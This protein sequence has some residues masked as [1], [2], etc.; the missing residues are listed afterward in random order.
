MNRFFAHAAMAAAIAVI[1]GCAA[2]VGDEG[3]GRR[4]ESLT[5][6][7]S[8]DADILS[9]IKGGATH[10]AQDGTYHHDGSEVMVGPKCY[11]PPCLIA[12]QDPN[13]ASFMPLDVFE[14]I[15]DLDYD[16]QTG[17]LVDPATSDEWEIAQGLCERIPCLV[18]QPF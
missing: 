13:E 10:D 2:E 5:V 1:G 17:R 7:G 15:R 12:V 16:G 18:L 3:V 8:I 4:T 9:D 6:Y 14:A 11:M